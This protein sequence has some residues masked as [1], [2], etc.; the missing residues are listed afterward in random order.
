[1]DFNAINI[2]EKPWGREVH[3]AVEEHYLGKILEVRR[4]HR[5]SLQYHKRKK[6]TMYVLEGVVRLT[7]GHD[8]EVVRAGASVTIEPGMRHRVE[9][10]EDSRIIEVST[11]HLEDVVR[12]EDD[13]GRHVD[14]GRH[15]MH[16]RVRAHIK[17][18]FARFIGGLGPRQIA[19]KAKGPQPIIR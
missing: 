16:R 12:L 15:P 13:H 19:P 3:F 18:T 7:L 2:V 14:S 9:A 6:E 5:L 8:I 17:N 1:M 4:G 11:K 10:I